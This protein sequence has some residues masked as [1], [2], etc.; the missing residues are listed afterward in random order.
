[1][2][3]LGPGAFGEIFDDPGGHAAGDAQRV[4]PLRLIETQRRSD[5]RRRAECAENRGGMEAGLVHAPGR[6]EAQSAHDF[7]AHRDAA[8]E[9]AA[10]EAV[11]LGGGERR[12]DDHDAGVHRAA[13]ERVVVVFTVA[14]GAVA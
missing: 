3:A 6:R 10:G 13:L 5:G 2:Q 7:A 14:A 4:D 12:R 11:L 8:G 1:M 9:V